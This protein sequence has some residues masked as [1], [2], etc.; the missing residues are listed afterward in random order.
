MLIRC[1]FD[2]NITDIGFILTEMSLKQLLSKWNWDGWERK[3]KSQ[4]KKPHNLVDKSLKLFDCYPLKNVKPDRTLQTGK[5]KISKMTNVFCKTVA[6][7]LD[8]PALGQ[9]TSCLNCCQLV[10]LIKEKFAI[11][12]DRGEINHFN[13]YSLEPIN[14]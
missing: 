1:R 6:I 10:E 3:T 11:T 9:S 13:H 14:L 4:L 12:V 5:T 8:E 7:A 2:F